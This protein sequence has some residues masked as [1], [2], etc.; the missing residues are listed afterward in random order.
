MAKGPS[1]LKKDSLGLLWMEVDTSPS[2]PEVM[3][4]WLREQGGC[5]MKMREWRNDFCGRPRFV[6]LELER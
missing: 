3:E 2:H 4:A 1:L 6:C 5:G